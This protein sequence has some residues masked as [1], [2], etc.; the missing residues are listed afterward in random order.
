M[1]DLFDAVHG[2]TR[3][4][5]TEFATFWQIYP[6]HVARK[7]AL[8]AFTKARRTTPLE[9]IMAGV[10]R[11]AT[12]VAGVEQQYILHGSTWL[13]GER[14]DDVLVPRGSGQ[15]KRGTDAL[16]EQLR[17]EIDGQGYG[18]PEDFGDGSHG[19]FPRLPH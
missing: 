3:P 1:T 9:T 16:R 8:T 11:Y 10:Q 2:T 13:T 18:G 15:P 14:W 7:A 4:V 19:R 5:T 6:R 17:Q 12:H